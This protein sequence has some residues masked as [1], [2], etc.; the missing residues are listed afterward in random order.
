[1][2]RPLFPFRAS[3]GGFKYYRHNLIHP[4]S[5]SHLN[6]HSLNLHTAKGRKPPPLHHTTPIMSHLQVLHSFTP[7]PPPLSLLGC[8]STSWLLPRL[9][10]RFRLG[11]GVP[12]SS[13]LLLEREG[14][15]LRRF[16]LGG[17]GTICFFLCLICWLFWDAVSEGAVSVD[18]DTDVGRLRER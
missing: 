15:G 9:L 16:L 4:I 14:L 11:L 6:C 8:R 13:T 2:S 1:M 5:Q 12:L 7:P 10:V 18:A 17:A 3:P